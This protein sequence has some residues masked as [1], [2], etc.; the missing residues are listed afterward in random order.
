MNFEEEFK[1]D[2]NSRLFNPQVEL[3]YRAWHEEDK[4]MI[5]DLNSLR[6]FHGVLQLDDYIVMPFTTFHDKNGKEIYHSDIL[7]VDD[8]FNKITGGDI[9]NV[10]V[11]FHEGSWMYGRSLHP[12]IMNTYLSMAVSM[13]KV[14]VI[15]NFY[16]NPGLIS[17]L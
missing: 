10:L 5:Y 7:N 2:W 14:E 12:L 4:V 1:K 6:V 8:D 3:K 11:G 15:G 9:K 17:S 13:K 16:Q